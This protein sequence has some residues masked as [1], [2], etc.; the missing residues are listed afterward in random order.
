MAATAT[1]RACVALRNDPWSVPRQPDV[2]LRR[3]RPRMAA[4]GPAVAGMARSYKM[5][6]I[7]L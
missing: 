4:P 2:R 3:S 1:L 6:V 5:Q 7:P